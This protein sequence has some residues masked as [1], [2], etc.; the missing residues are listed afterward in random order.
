MNVKFLY[1]V[2]AILAVALIFVLLKPQPTTSCEAEAVAEAQSPIE[3]DKY[4]R[5]TLTVAESKRLIAKGLLQ[6]A[7]VVQS[8]ASG[9]IVVAKGSTNHYL[10]EELMGA[11]IEK[12]AFLSGNIQPKGNTHKP[13][14]EK[15]YGELYLKSGVDQGLDL[16][17]ALPKISK[18]ALL[19]KGANLINYSAGKAALLIGHPTGGTLGAMLPYIESGV[20]KLIIPVGLEKN[21][22]FDIDHL[23]AEFSAKRQGVLQVF[24][25]P[26]ELFT[27]IEAIEQFAAV[28]VLQIASGGLNG[29]EGAVTL[30]IRGTENEIQKVK[31]LLGEVQG[32]AAFY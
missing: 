13:Q 2:I 8:L 24:E 30:S 10:Y 22:S 26:G 14:I 28:E 17:E 19:F 21:S 3:G 15:A 32:E 12:G 23:A 9:E 18:G 16:G 1:A 5:A 27:E 6:Y 7:P 25:M 29:A 11:K 20:A 31:A 4:L